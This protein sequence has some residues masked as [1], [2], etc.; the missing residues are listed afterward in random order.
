MSAL[1]IAAEEMR[2]G[3]LRSNDIQSNLIGQEENTVYA[4][5]LHFVN[6]IINFRIPVHIGAAAANFYD[7][8]SQSIGAHFTSMGSS[9][10]AYDVNND[11]NRMP[12]TGYHSSSK[13]ATK[14]VSTIDMVNGISPY[15]IV[16]SLFRLSSNGGYILL[17]LNKY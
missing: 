10:R 13:S 11:S 14:R 12:S 16:D 8:S 3:M 7:D 4:Q 9:F 5:I 6:L 15:G 1:E 2:I 17:F